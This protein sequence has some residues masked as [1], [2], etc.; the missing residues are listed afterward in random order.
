MKKKILSI[1]VAVLLIAVIACMLVGCRS[2]EVSHG[3]NDVTVSVNAEVIKDGNLKFLVDAL[4]YLAKDGGLTYTL[5]GSMVTQ[6]D[7]LENGANYNPCIMIY[8]DSQNPDYVSEEWG[9]YQM[10]EVTYKSVTKGV[11]ELPVEAD[12]TYVFVL[13][14]F[15]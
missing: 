10:G 7:D 2:Y 11:T 3:E 15:D 13:T 8:S 12:V 4:D 9:T 6:I 14:T 5:T 1:A